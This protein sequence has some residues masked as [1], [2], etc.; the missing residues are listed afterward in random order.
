[1]TDEFP[2]A[3]GFDLSH[4]QTNYV[5]RQ[6]TPRP[7]DFVIQKLTEA[8]YIDP[9]YE[10]LKTAIQPIPIRGGYHY[11]R[12]PALG[13]WKSQC[14]AFLNA[15]TS[16]YH[17]WMMDAEKA[18]NYAGLKIFDKPAD[19]YVETIVPALEYLTSQTSRPGLLYTGPDLWN[20]WLRPYQA[21]L[22]KYDLCVAHY[23]YKPDPTKKPNYY[24]IK[25]CSNMRRDWRFWQYDPNG[26]GGRGRE[27]GVESKGLDLDVFNGTVEDLHAWAGASNAPPPPFPIPDPQPAANTYRL[28]KGAW[29][30]SGP[31]N[32][33]RARRHINRG[34]VVTVQAFVGA[35]AQL[36]EG[37]YVARSLLIEHTP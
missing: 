26:Q 3:H 22:L 19:G 31:G 33:Y 29:A 11:M 36:T 27:Y 7:V 28:T 23:W 30:L 8:I 16:D 32:Q 35:W 14:N 37:D 12:G 21:E 18:Y 25:G 6:K 24:T 1:M 20:T 2:R 13:A 17:F 4:W 10:K 5:H 34:T 15:L 9:L